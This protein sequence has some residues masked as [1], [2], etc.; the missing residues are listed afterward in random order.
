MEA[1]SN[2]AQLRNTTLP[3]IPEEVFQFSCNIQ[4][5][6]STG[7]STTSS[8]NNEAQSSGSDS[9]IDTNS[10]SRIVASQS[11]SMSNLTS[12]IGLLVQSN[13]TIS[14]LVGKEIEPVC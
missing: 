7:I 14:T 5:E 8:V 3:P 4:S 6:P 1:T 11:E 10:L 9:Q 13:S 2:T 12:M